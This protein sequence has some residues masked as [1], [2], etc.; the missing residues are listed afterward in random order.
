M[1]F[2]NPRDNTQFVHLARRVYA[3][4]NISSFHKTYSQACKEPHSYLFLDLTQSINIYLDI[5]QR[6]SLG[7]S[8]R[9]LHLF[10][11]MSRLQS[12]LQILQVLK[13]AKPQARRA[14]LASADEELIKAIVGCALNSLNGKYKLT[15]EEKCKWKK[16]KSCLRALIDP[17][18]SFKSKRKL[19]LQ[20]SGFIFPMLASVFSDIIGSLISNNYN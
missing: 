18:I 3:A 19:L 20:K 7:K 17:N 15:K 10:S 14:L 8:A 1:V 11:V 16:Y 9:F 6:F 13:D 4:K 12:Q 2:K 5:E